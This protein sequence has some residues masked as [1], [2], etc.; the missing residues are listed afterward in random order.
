MKKKASIFSLPFLKHIQIAHNT[1]SFFFDRSGSAI[2]FLP[3]Q[4]IRMT[5]PHKSSDERGT[6]RY[7][8]IA[9]SPLEKKY[10]MVTTKMVQ[11]TFKETLHNLTLG[12]EVHFFGPMGK[13][14]FDENDTTERVFISGGVGITPFHSM[15]TYVAKK[16][17]S[18]P[19]TLIAC[20]K[21][22]E[23]VIFYEELAQLAKEQRNLRVVYAVHSAQ[24]WKG[25]RGQLSE[26][27]LKKYL[28]DLSSVRF[29][30]VGSPGMVTKTKELLLSLNIQ[31]IKTEDFT[32]Y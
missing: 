5:L 18:M 28:S 3:G 27:L 9:S 15:L 32:G 11:S 31:H 23:E 6:S 20:F 25:E 19:I 29:A 1:Y 13:F 10:L 2:D 14:V 17:L 4:Y 22:E 24:K 21:T 16:N 26:R 8:T 12:K 7:F 30:V